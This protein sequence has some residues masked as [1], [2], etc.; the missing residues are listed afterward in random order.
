MIEEFQKN[1]I[2]V[3]LFTHPHHKY[4]LENVPE[5]SEKEFFKIIDNL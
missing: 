2:D 3:I 5:E 4:Y 1:N